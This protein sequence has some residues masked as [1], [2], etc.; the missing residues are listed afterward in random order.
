M[1]N[2]NIPANIAVADGSQNEEEKMNE[3]SHKKVSSTPHSPKIVGPKKFAQQAQTWIEKIESENSQIQLWT[4]NSSNIS[5]NSNNNTEYIGIINKVVHYPSNILTKQFADRFRGTMDTNAFHVLR[6]KAMTAVGHKMIR[7]ACANK[8]GNAVIGVTYNF[9][10]D[11]SYYNITLIV[12][13]TCIKI[14]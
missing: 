11:N 8:G 7:K 6:L 2:T 4:S 5:S 14:K 3:T 9:V 10:T 13:G 12:S 1:G